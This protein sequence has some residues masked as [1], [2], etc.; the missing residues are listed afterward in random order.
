M[1]ALN[2]LAER[3][4][5][6]GALTADEV[7]ALRRQMWPDGRIGEDEA[8]LLFALND[9][10]KDPS[11]EWVDFFVEALTH[12]IVAQ[13]EPRGYIDDA[14]AAWLSERIA[15]D[16]KVESS[17]ELELLVK[18]LESAT[19]AP[20]GLKSFALA[21]IER[22][23]L[24]GAGPTRCGG[25]LE[26]GRV[27]EAEVNL[28]RR[29]IFAQAGDGPGAVS[30]AEAEALFRIKDAS[31]GA[32]NAAGWQQLFVQGVGNHLMAYASYEPLERDEAARLEAFMDDT[33]VRV[34]GFFS[35]VAGAAFS[36][37]V[38]R[39]QSKVPA[40]DH[41]AAVAAANAVTATENA[42]LKARIDA[43]DALDPL[44]QALLDFLAAESGSADD[45]RQTP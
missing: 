27:S 42:W 18:V 39:G 15:R 4:R 28:L 33:S 14:K 6:A 38:F 35:R 19:A 22:A 12:H 36:G 32:D 2:D 10:A 31:L 3:L 43:D 30:A 23:V 9:A 16:G 37:A 40:A 24:T 5:A 44:E 45:P 13:T 7:L 25:A 29:L 1:S 21:E 20:Q 26:P 34:G 41:D 8:D 17:A 11:R